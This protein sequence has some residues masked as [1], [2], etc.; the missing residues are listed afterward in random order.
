MLHIDDSHGI[1]TAEIKKGEFGME[2]ISGKNPSLPNGNFLSHPLDR[3][4]SFA[5]MAQL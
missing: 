2:K 4:Q 3:K 1:Q 5:R